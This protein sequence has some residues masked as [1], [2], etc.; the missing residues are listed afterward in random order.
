MDNNESNNKSKDK[1]IKNPLQVKD[2][3]IDNMLNTL[4][5]ELH[6]GIDISLLEGMSEEEI[7]KLDK[8]R[9]NKLLNKMD[10]VG[11]VNKRLEELY[12]DF[13]EEYVVL[14][15]YMIMT[16]YKDYDLIFDDSRGG[17]YKRRMITSNTSVFE[18]EFM[19]LTIET[20]SN[21]LKGK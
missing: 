1:I 15:N 21:I 6:N 13:T 14:K 7:K 4:N 11:R 16:K 10:I 3:V 18:S 12:G 2:N 19:K 5:N 9:D 20:L 17:K 8:E